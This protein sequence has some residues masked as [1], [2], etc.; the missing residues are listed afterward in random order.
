MKTRKG[1]L[2]RV[3]KKHGLWEFIH[4]RDNRYR[5]KQCISERYRQM[6]YDTKTEAGNIVWRQVRVMRLQP[7]IEGFALPPH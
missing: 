1:R 5:C 4:T 3:C 7:L 2:V 6:S